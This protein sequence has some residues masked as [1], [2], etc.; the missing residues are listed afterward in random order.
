MQMSVT[1][2]TARRSQSAT[3]SPAQTFNRLVQANALSAAKEL[4]QDLDAEGLEHCIDEMRV[5]MHD[6]GIEL[7]DW[8]QLSEHEL[9]KIALGAFHLRDG[10]LVLA[11]DA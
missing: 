7:P 11:V 4:L 1:R 8:E 2:R 6:H 10:K 3:L 5:L 9:R